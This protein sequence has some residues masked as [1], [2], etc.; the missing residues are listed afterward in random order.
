MADFA[1]CILK[2]ALCWLHGVGRILHGLEVLCKKTIVAVFENSHSLDISKELEF[3]VKKKK[4]T[5]QT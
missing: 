2:K 4:K 5:K 1:A 3:C